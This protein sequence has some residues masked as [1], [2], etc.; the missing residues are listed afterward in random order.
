M[1]LE[2]SNFPICI[3]YCSLSVDYGKNIVAHSLYPYYNMAYLC[4]YLL[5]TSFRHP[6]ATSWKITGNTF[7]IWTFSFCI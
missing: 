4:S 6:G 1:Y 2:N 5:Q 3:I 7:L